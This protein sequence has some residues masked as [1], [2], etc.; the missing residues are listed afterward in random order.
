MQG[1]DTR[2]KGLQAAKVN[3]RKRS[4]YLLLH[5]WLS[6][7]KC[8]PK[9]RIVSPG[10]SSCYIQHR[11]YDLC[12][13]KWRQ[14]IQR[15][16][17]LPRIVHGE[18][19]ITLLQLGYTFHP[20]PL[21]GTWWRLLGGAAK[22]TYCNR[23]SS[24]KT[25][26]CYA[27]VGINSNN[28]CVLH[29]LRENSSHQYSLL[30]WLQARGVTVRRHWFGTHFEHCKAGQNVCNLVAVQQTTKSIFL[31]SIFLLLLH[32]VSCDADIIIGRYQ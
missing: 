6:L 8:L 17:P 27:C 7:P 18:M 10:S 30:H 1:R 19:M 20:P 24:K 22:K 32:S 23:D 11:L 4:R 14:S 21:V 31:W 25:V 13:A 29:S 16:N 3:M 9:K 5:L 26:L 12:M 28:P 15:R 2:I